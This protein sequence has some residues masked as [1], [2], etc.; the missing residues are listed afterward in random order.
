MSQVRVGNFIPG[1]PSFGY[2]DHDP[3]GPQ[4]TQVIGDIGSRQIKVARQLCWVAGVIQETHEDTRA[5]RVGHRSAE[6][7]HNVNT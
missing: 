2:S 7:V 5:G 6:A 4:A 1:L 3:A